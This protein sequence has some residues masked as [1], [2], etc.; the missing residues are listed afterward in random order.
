MHNADTANTKANI[1]PY[2]LSRCIF[3]YILIALRQRNRE[4][5]TAVQMVVNQIGIFSS[6]RDMMLLLGKW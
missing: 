3:A 2:V 6:G 5:S 4:K 1:L